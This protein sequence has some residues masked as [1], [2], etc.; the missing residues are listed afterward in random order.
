M[1]VLPLPE[2]LSLIPL[3]AAYCNH[4]SE[5]LGVQDFVSETPLLNC[6]VVHHMLL[7]VSPGSRFAVIGTDYFGGAGSQSAVVYEGPN[8]LM[9]PKEAE[10]GPINEA[11]RLLGVK[12]RRG[13]DEFDTIGLHQWRSFDEMF[14]RYRP[15]DNG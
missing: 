5:E 8:P 14:E 2:G 3:D 11:L 13:R 1:K 7:H 10:V 12:A 6:R 4:W 15:T 9:E